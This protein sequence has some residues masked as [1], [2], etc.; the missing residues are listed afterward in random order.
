MASPSSIHDSSKGLGVR[1]EKAEKRFGSLIALRR[2]SLEITPGEFVVLVGHNG[3]GKTTLLRMAALLS[4][5]T[6]GKVT[7]TGGD[8]GSTASVKRRL[9][10]VGHYTLLYDE[11]TAEENLRFFARLYGLDASHVAILAALAP[12]GLAG[13]AKDLV[14]TFSRGMRQRLAIARALLNEP[15]MLLF[16]EPAAGLDRAGAAWL[17]ATLGALRNG[18]CTVIMSSHGQN[19]ALALATRAIA[20]RDG[21]ILADSGPRGD[22]Q[23]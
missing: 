13:R 14:R 18:G 2:V 15:R 3:S 1:F 17:S 10:M 12:A 5:P 16:D 7:Y 6:A 8:A 22:A 21:Q 9:G 19:E 20:M 23:G 4:R 11:L